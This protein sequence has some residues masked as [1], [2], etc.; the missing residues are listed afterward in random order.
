MCLYLTAHRQ[1]QANELLNQ[2][3]NNYKFV[4]FL[5]EAERNE[6]LNRLG[7]KDLLAACFQRLTKYPL[8]LGSLLNTFDPTTRT[9]ERRLLERAVNRSK[10][11]LGQVNALVKQEA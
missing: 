5:S 8:L 9:E 7:L 2:K 6:S 10:E 1:A 11:I 4:A 3:R